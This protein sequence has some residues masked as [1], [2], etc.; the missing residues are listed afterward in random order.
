VSTTAFAA[1]LAPER[2]LDPRVLARID[3]LDLVA[4]SVVEGF[5]SGL[6]KAVFRGASPDFAEYRA[7]TP[8]DD[9]RRVD[10]RVYARSDRL[11]VKTFEAETNADV[12]LAID[13]SASMGFASG[14]VS[15]LDY[16]RMAL[17][18]LT[19]L[20]GRQRDRVG[21]LAFRDA[22]VER[23]PPSARQRVALLHALARQQAR[24]GGDLAVAC[25]RMAAL[26]GRRGIWVVA[27][28]F[29]CEPRRAMA[30]LDALRLRGHDV[31]ALHILDPQEMDLGLS[32]P[33]VLQDMETGARMPVTPAGQARYRELMRE[34]V[35]ALHTG[36][37]ERG[38]DHACLLTDR[39]LDEMLWHYLSQRARLARLP[40]GG[41]RA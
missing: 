26:P 17:A 20:A 28:D 13:V 37:R 14:E 23:I 27:S 31:I 41:G 5:I 30:A 7:Y 9:V 38:M 39:P 21:L 22:V 29:Y 4:R 16:A 19:H 15:K 6:H 18:A 40:R 11:Y 1:G 10:W 2:F 8:G 36:L 32:G 34:H 35:D 24:D 3:N 25:E 12:N 33:E